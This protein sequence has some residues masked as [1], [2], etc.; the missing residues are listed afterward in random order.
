[1]IVNGPAGAFTLTAKAD[2]ID[3]SKDGRRAAVLDYKSG[4]SYPHKGIVSGKLP[5]LP[6]EMLILENGGFGK[7]ITVPVSKLSYIVVNGGGEGGEMKPLTD[8]TK[9]QEARENAKQGLEDLIAAFDNP[10]MPYYSLPRPEIAPKYNDY[11]HLAAPQFVIVPCL[12]S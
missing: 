6:L 1:M 3:K 7:D 11:E 10:D 5:Q 12:S 4:G 8:P 2:R 9:L